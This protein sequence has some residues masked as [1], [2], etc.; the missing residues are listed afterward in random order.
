MVVS[1]QF[2]EPW[3]QPVNESDGEVS[4]YRILG[5]LLLLLNFKMRKTC[6]WMFSAALFMT[7]KTWKQPRC[8]SVGEHGISDSGILFSDKKKS[9]AKKRQEGTLSEYCSLKEVNL[10]ILHTVQFQLYDIL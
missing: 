9:Q 6:T 4:G 2:L 5:G 7:A 1:N 10:K 3:S 8:P